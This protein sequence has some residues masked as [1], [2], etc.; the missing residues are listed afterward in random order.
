VLGVGDVDYE[1]CYDGTVWQ[2]DISGTAGAT[3]KLAGL[4]GIT[5]I[6]PGPGFFTRSVLAL[7]NDGT[8]WRDDGSGQFTPVYGLSGIA[9]IG[10]GIGVYYASTS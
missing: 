8:V 9:A 2:L 6:A 3:K 1:R 7:K 5:D 4:S 10:G